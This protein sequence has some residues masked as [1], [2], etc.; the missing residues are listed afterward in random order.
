MIRVFNLEMSNIFRFLGVLILFTNTIVFGQNQPK[1]I[2]ADFSNVTVTNF[3]EHIA[4]SVPYQ[5]FYDSRATDT[6]KITVKG[7]Y[8]S[9][10]S[11]LEKAFEQT[12]L[13][14]AITPKNKVIITQNIAIKTELPLGFFDIGNYQEEKIDVVSFNFEQQEKEEKL[15][16]AVENKLFN[17][18]RKTSSIT[19]GSANLAGHV[20]DA[21]SGEAVVGAVVYVLNPT[22]SVTTDQFGYYSITL[23][24]GRHEL[25]IKYFGMKETQRQ[26]MLYDDGKLNI[27]LY[28]DV[29]ALKAVVIEADKDLNIS[30]NQMGLNKLDMATLKQVPTVLGERDVVKIALTL[31]GVQS[32][33]EGASGFNV[34]GGAVDQNLVTINNAA[35]YNS[36]HFFGF[37]S[38][39]NPDV[40]KSVD[41]YKSGIPAQYGGR[42]SSI[43]N[44]KTRDGNK[45]NFTGAGGIS[46]ITGRFTLE[47]PIVKDQTSFILGLRSTYSN[48]LIRQVPDANIKNSK[49]FFH[50]ISGKIS[51]KLG[52][53]DDIYLSTYYSKDGFKLFSDSVYRYKNFNTS[54]QW[55]HIFNNQ[56]YAV[57]GAI[58]SDYNYSLSNESN[59]LSAFNLS[60]G[61][62]DTN[63]KLDFSYFPKSEH[64]IDFGISSIYYQLKPG[65]YSTLGDSSVIIP[66]HLEPEKGIESAIYA[67]NE[68]DLNKRLKVYFGLRYSLYQYLGP[69][70]DFIYPK[71]LPRTIS[72]ITDTVFYDKNDI[73][74]TYHGPEYR[75]SARFNLNSNSSIKFSFNRMRQY[76][77]MLSNTAAVS[78]TD[79]WK[80]S[81]SHLRPQVG[82]QISL[83]YYRN[84]QK[85][86]V[87]LSVEAYYKKIKDIVD[88]KGGA[89]LLL[90]EHIETDLIN[91]EGKAYGIEFLLKR[92][93]G[94]LN[95]WISYTYARTFI[96]SVEGIPEE[97]INGGEFFNANY[98]KP[99][100]LNIIANYKINRRLDFS[101]NLVYSTGR[102]VTFPV[103]K[104]FLGETERI[105][106][107]NRNE[108]RVPDYIR[109]DLSMQVEGNHKVEKPM[110]SSWS[111]SLYNV[112]GR[113]NVYSIYFQSQG[114]RVKGYK[115]SVFGSA[116][117]TVTYNFRF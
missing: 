24:K 102:P 61:I 99:H 100:S 79:T 94:K 10:R 110:H 60:Y 57:L 30:S 70:T 113:K 35:V 32:V 36:A 76:I 19:S 31:P 20:R 69:Q 106:Y 89:K 115:L 67:G 117:P 51:H 88:F 55:K 22:I 45:K 38:V 37:F 58:Y 111:F 11:L 64:K 26:I 87:E 68:I 108:F 109:L 93:H 27:N 25:K 41:L 72:N 40:I 34:R 59:A 80:L 101:A 33:G 66:V 46:P 39:F 1:N 2:N 28:E 107:S 95:G 44:V 74:K 15:Q 3:V 104:Y 5:F 114:S 81:D 85:Y 21:N 92:K 91:G 23:P 17:I 42:I 105:Y 84:F 48:W 103:S 96:R 43:F 54:L 83:G 4:K 13:E 75:A 53:K 18:G 112:L 16:F 77:H 116:I 71:N 52:E 63:F 9:L 47:G 65:D 86:P 73:I 7:V 14:F 8:P 50:D 29:I 56:F 49:A 98:D 62:K 97:E 12:D 6:L 78:P 82:D 90:N